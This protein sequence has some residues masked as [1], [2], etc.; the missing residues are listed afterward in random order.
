MMD[1]IDRQ[2]IVATQGGLP[3]VQRPYQQ[4]AETL[5]ISSDAVMARLQSMLDSG[6]IRRIAAVPNHYKLGYRANGM[7]VWN[8]AD[9]LIASAGP[10]VAEQHYV[11]HCY[12]RPRHLPAWPYNLFAMVHGRD[13]AE[14][15]RHYHSIANMLDDICH[16][17]QIL[18]S[19]RILK[20]SGFRI[21]AQ[22]QENS[23]NV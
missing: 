17:H 1:A 15:E 21:R 8:I 12:Q 2:L 23:A 11:S 4:L 9:E 5:G 6:I 7:T 20:K 18:F 22:R 3:L 10:M 14:A 19:T 13:R 16:E